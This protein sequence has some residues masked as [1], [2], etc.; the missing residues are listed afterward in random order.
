MKLLKWLKTKFK[1][2]YCNECANQMDKEDLYGN[3][4]C[5]AYP[6]VV[7]RDSNT[8]LERGEI[9]VVHTYHTCLRQKRCKYCFRYIAKKVNTENN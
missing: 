2:V 5:K 3:L 1:T 6:I 4:L 8:L 9:K 7:E